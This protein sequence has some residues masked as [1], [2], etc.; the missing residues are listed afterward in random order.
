MEFTSIT[1][2][3][4][5]DGHQTEITENYKSNE[6]S[7]GR[8]E[9]SLNVP[10]GVDRDNKVNTK[11][12]IKNKYM[13]CEKDLNKTQDVLRYYKNQLDQN[14]AQLVELNATLKSCKLNFNSTQEVVYQKQQEVL[15]LKEQIQKDERNTNS[16]IIHS[17]SNS[18]H[19]NKIPDFKMFPVLCIDGWTIIQQ[20]I[21]GNEN[22]NRNWE[23]YK[24]GFGVFTGDFFLGLEKIHRLMNDQPHELII[25]LEKFDGTNYHARYKNFKIAGEDDKYKLLS[26]GSFSGNSTW[27]GMKYLV[28]QQ[29]STIDSDND[30]WMEGSCAKERQAGWWFR[31]CALRYKL[32]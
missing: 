26:L 20:R 13:R 6:D 24:N 14:A 25:H 21:N 28:G 10:Q 8:N 22:F 2:K 3:C 29:F 12:R 15:R 32:S 23:D 18:N 1:C 9:L 4:P 19:Y 11:K 17:N 16:V 5:C 31:K 30:A 7:L 27:N